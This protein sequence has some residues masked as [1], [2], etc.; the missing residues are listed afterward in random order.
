MTA[1]QNFD[2]TI[3]LSATSTT[4]ITQILSLVEEVGDQHLSLY[5]R[6]NAS[7]ENILNMTEALRISN[8]SVQVFV[9]RVAAAM[10]Q[11]ED[12]RAMAVAA[13]MVLAGKFDTEN[14]NNSRELQKLEGQ[15][16]HFPSTVVNARQIVE[17]AYV[18][19]MEA[20]VT[21]DSAQVAVDAK[22]GEMSAKLE[23]AQ[24]TVVN[25]TRAKTATDSVKSVVDILKV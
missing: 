23:E 6:A 19:L 10:I 20:N 7:W 2:G 22:M 11:L 16:Q 15:M 1:L 9:E 18:K 5:Q 25:A 4:S 21:I 3:E 8:G 24:T 13:D 17:D 12:A 14:Q